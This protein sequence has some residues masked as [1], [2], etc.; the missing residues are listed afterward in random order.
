ML[1]HEKN[2]EQT[3][4]GVTKRIAYIDAWETV[5]NQI[6]LKE[7]VDPEWG[8]NGAKFKAFKNKVQGVN[9]SLN[10]SFAKFDYAESDKFM[11]FR[12]VI[13]F[14]RWFIRM[15]LNRYQFRGSIRNPKYRYDAAVGDTVMGFHVE[16][17]RALFRGIQSR[18]EYFTFL[19]PSE[20]AALWK[21]TMDVAYLILF[22]MAISMIFGFD[23]DDEDKFEKIRD[24]SGPLPFFGVSENEADFKL[25]G[26]LTNHALLMT[27]Q[28]KNET[29]QWLP[30]PGLGAD[31]YLEMLKLDAI[32]MK[33]TLDNYKKM[34]GALGLVAGNALFGI[35]DTKAYW[36][37]REGPYSWMQE[38]EEGSKAMSYFFRSF[39]ITGKSLDPAQA[40]TNWVKSSNWR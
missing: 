28:L 4:N 19:S 13:A 3:I 8:I 35:D 18:G 32:A 10:G 34:G 17:M 26:W 21:T 24:R 11:A 36:D 25:G 27:M 33:N 14:K 38:G 15:F 37:Q 22:S 2:V 40:T 39:G 31:N 29:V 30:L 12:F 23:E 5:D 1:N 6:R 9:N 20:K 16:A 7:G